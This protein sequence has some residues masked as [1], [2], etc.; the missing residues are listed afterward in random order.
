VKALILAC[1]SAHALLVLAASALTL[2]IDAPNA[3]RP[4]LAVVLIVPLLLFARG[5]WQARRTSL[6]ALAVLLVAYIG[7]G[8]VEVLATGGGFFAAA[9]LAAAAAEFIL[10]LLLLRRRPASAPSG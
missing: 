7:F 10:C 6:R 9:L 4:L 2:T 1:R 8:T 3:L 5:L